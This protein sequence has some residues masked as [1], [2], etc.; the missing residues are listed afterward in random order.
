[1][2]LDPRT[3]VQTRVHNLR[4]T[5]S[6]HSIG[7]G[8]KKNRSPKRGRRPC[9]KIFQWHIRRCFERL[10]NRGRCHLQYNE[11]LDK[12]ANDLVDAVNTKK[13][14]MEPGG[15]TDLD[16]AGWS[17]FVKRFGRPVEPGRQNIAFFDLPLEIR[18]SIYD[19]VEFPDRK[20][21][22]F[23]PLDHTPQTYIDVDLPVWTSSTLLRTSKAVRDDILAFFESRLSEPFSVS[24][25]MN[26]DKDRYPQ[27]SLDL[28]KHQKS[29]L[30]TPATSVV[31]FRHITC[32]FKTESDRWTEYLSITAGWRL[33]RMFAPKLF[34]RDTVDVLV[35]RYDI[36]QHDDGPFD[37]T[38]AS[39]SRNWQV[40]VEEMQE[41]VVR[42]INERSGNGVSMIEV[43]RMVDIMN[44]HFG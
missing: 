16:V 32:L 24:I 40:I 39:C 37:D 17:G 33:G 29:L 36:T 35:R 9:S 12:D 27:F 5:L 31:D 10:E 30:T 19:L 28:K 20:T 14:R 11:T 41:T 25:T 44:R 23:S 15:G 42:S 4:E 43:V 2:K 3:G 13:S 1:M 21:Y 34:G 26:Q 22:M 38:Y 18:Q 8:A 6:R 7:N